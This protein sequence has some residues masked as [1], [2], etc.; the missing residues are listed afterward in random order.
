MS[1]LSLL[2]INNH[3]SEFFE[4]NLHL[5][6]DTYGDLYKLDPHREDNYLRH[7]FGNFYDIN[8]WFLH[9]PVY[10]IKIKDIEVEVYGKESTT[11]LIIHNID[12]QYVS[13]GEKI[14]PNSWLVDFRSLW[15]TG[16]YSL[17]ICDTWSVEEHISGL[18]EI[19][20]F[21][22]KIDENRTNF[23]L[24]LKNEKHIEMTDD[25]SIGLTNFFLKNKDEII[26]DFEHYMKDHPA[27]T[28]G[29]YTEFTSVLET[30]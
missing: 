15:G 28:I 18:I 29:K 30:I 25:T 12:L 14:Q 16:G 26:L 4:E 9:T 22:R 13:H 5:I 11:F 24:F 6:K 8:K 20:A 19:D 7:I 27:G 17:N 21:F 10:K 23:L 1:R 2:D 3:D